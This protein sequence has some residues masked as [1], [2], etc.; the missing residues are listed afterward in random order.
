M[1]IIVLK[2][3]IHRAVVTQS[4]L[5]YEGS[6]TIDANLLK[7]TQIH[8]YERVMISNINRGTRFETYA[9]AGKPGSGVICL[10]GAAARLCKI[11]DRVTIMA[12]ALMKP[13]EMKKSKPKVIV[14]DKNNHIT[15][16]KLRL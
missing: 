15:N 14:L 5:H 4:A 8:P 11:G 10:N 16:P 12:F 7:K 6:I 3:K 13:G 2:S 9:I 1:E